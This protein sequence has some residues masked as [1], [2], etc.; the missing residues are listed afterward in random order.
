MAPVPTYIILAITSLSIGFGYMFRDFGKAD[1]TRY[2]GLMLVGLPMLCILFVTAIHPLFAGYCVFPKPRQSEYAVKSK[3]NLPH[4][5]LGFNI[6]L[7]SRKSALTG[8]CILAVC[9]AGTWITLKWFGDKQTHVYASFLLLCCIWASIYFFF[10][11][12]LGFVPGDYGILLF[13]TLVVYGDHVMTL[14]NRDMEDRMLWFGGTSMVFVL[15]VRRS[16]ICG[17]VRGNVEQIVVTGLSIVGGVFLGNGT[18]LVGK[19]M[20]GCLVV[21]MVYPRGIARLG[22][23]VGLLS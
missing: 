18:V 13:G 11:R 23:L 6:S 16:S 21:F 1:I 3:S 9:A 4:P 20:L 19:V 7:P 2:I 14:V 22:R 12:R 17:F 5:I 8:I 10:G 15:F